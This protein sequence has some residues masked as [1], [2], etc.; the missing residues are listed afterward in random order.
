MNNGT[1]FS[2]H[3]QWKSFRYAFA[4]ILGFFRTEHNARVHLL[5]AIAVTILSFV[6]RVT[7]TEAIALIIVVAF[8]WVSEMLN[9][10]IEKTM[11]M[12]SEE[13]HPK[14]KIIK[15]IAAGAVLI[16]AIA[17]LLTGLL[18][19]VPKFLHV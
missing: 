12:I 3:S 17:A 16:A 1:K 9:T 19:F 14:I 11:D 7:N 10:C 8:V 2:M 15:D 13:Y 5:A 6:F 4:G 18:V